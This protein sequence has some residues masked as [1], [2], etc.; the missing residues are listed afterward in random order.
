MTEV[1]ARILLWGLAGAGKTTTLQTI[2]GKLREDLRGEIQKHPTRL[3]PTV[4][5]ESLS[6]SL[7]D[8]GGVATEIEIIAVPGADDQNMTRKQLLDE[9]DGV[10][11]VLDCAPERIE[12]NIAAFE[13]LEASLGDYGRNLEDCP[14]VLQ[15]NKRDLADPFAI[16]DLHRRLDVSQAAVFETIATTGHGVLPTLTTISKHVVRAHRSPTAEGSTPVPATAEATV[17]SYEDMQETAGSEALGT[18]SVLE[19]A[20]LAEADGEG[21]DDR[22]EPIDLD[23]AAPPL[24][25]DWHSTSDA[26]GPSDPPA[27][28]DSVLGADLRIVSV[29]QAAVDAEGGVQLPLVL[30]DE[31]GQTRPVVLSLRLDSLDRPGGD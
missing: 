26:G 16:E 20:I 24:Q 14:I 8:V 25:P 19:D 28:P 3:D 11:L 17:P 23:F 12:D 22:T 5:Y 13:E 4:Q 6:I 21:L 29:G 9:I 7:G 10:V 18:H 2:H 15:Y 1:H 31:E 27:K 30:G